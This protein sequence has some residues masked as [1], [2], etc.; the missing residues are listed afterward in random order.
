MIIYIPLEVPVRELNGYLLF[1]MNAAS[2]GHQTLIASSTDL[3]LY[4]RLKLIKAGAY[5]KKNIN[6]WPF[7][8]T[9]HKR[10]TEGGFDF[11]CHEQEPPIL[12][13][14]IN[15][16]IARLNLSPDQPFPMK[17]VFCWGDRDAEAYS[18][19]FQRDNVFFSTGSMRIDL[20]KSK[21]I[22]D[23]CA[24]SKPY[25]LFVS[26][27]AGVLFGK[28]HF[29]EIYRLILSLNQ[30]PTYE[31][32]SNFLQRLKEECDVGL[33]MVAL[34]LYL[35]AKGID[36]RLVVRPHPNDRVDYWCNIFD[37]HPNVEVISNTDSITP[38][39]TGAQAVVQN[40]CTSALEAV[41]QGIPVIGYGPDRPHTDLSIPNQLS[42]RARTPEEFESAL[43]QIA[44]G[45]FADHQA[46]SEDIL[47]P[48]VKT[49]G[50]AALEMIRIM[51]EK[52]SFPADQWLTS[53][54][55]L[56]LRLARTSKNAIDWTR[57][58]VQF[59]PPGTPGYQMDARVIKSSISDISKIMR[60]PVP[61][62]A[63]ITKSGLLVSPLPQERS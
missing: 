39:I 60:L 26:N 19:F 47:R 16:F 22:H 7:S 2:R 12:M 11:Y 28:K 46:Q 21:P 23:N 48:L 14:D 63:F 31:Y 17:A 4:Q 55:V 58:L 36:Q 9:V 18:K 25:I 44:E 32:E 40:S 61:E 57:R 24:I 62:L 37:R 35:A 51:E 29:S 53:L 10:F 42:I 41:I 54:D 8:A 3:W 30:L 33:S 45:K 27:F 43:Q 52:S 49:R 38:W 15:K 6:V 5:L 1:A 13:D 56:K 59:R 34:I 50:N 20:W